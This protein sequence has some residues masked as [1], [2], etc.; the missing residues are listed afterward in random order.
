V[1]GEDFADIEAYGQ[2]RRLGELAQALK[3]KGYRANPVRRVLSPNRTASSVPWLFQRSGTG[4]CR[5]Q[6]SGCSRRYSPT[7]PSQGGT[8]AEVQAPIAVTCARQR[9]EY[10]RLGFHKAA[11][12]RA[13]DPQSGMAGAGRARPLPGDAALAHAL[14]DG[15]VRV[16][17]RT[18]SSRRVR[19]ASPVNATSVTIGV[20]CSF[21]HEPAGADGAAVETVTVAWPFLGVGMFP[22][23]PAAV[24]VNC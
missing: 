13:E 1:D 12:Q 8:A 18:L 3:E 16:S 23:A 14:L 11:S 21:G 19:V 22:V 17:D 20:H 5:R 9:R 15:H 10:W 6:R 24:K 4:W 2:E 7:K